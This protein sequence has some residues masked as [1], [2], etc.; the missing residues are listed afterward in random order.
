M[1]LKQAYEAMCEDRNLR[2]RRPDFLP[3]TFLWMSRGAEAHLM[4]DSVDIRSRVTMLSLEFA[5]AEDFEVI[6]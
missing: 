3:N 5:L 2:V 4:H 6:E 1:T